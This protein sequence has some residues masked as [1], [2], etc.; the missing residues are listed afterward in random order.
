MCPSWPVGRESLEGVPSTLRRACGDRRRLD[1]SRRGSVWRRPRWADGRLIGPRDDGISHWVK[2][3]VGFSAAAGFWLHGQAG[4][5][6]SAAVPHGRLVLVLLMVASACLLL[7]SHARFRAL[8]AR[9]WLSGHTSAPEFGLA[10]TWRHVGTL[11]Y[12]P[13]GVMGIVS[14]RRAMALAESDAAGG[15]EDVALSGRAPQQ[16]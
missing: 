7:V 16:V 3:I 2:F 4:I 1:G 8:V 14:S 5:P 6:T 11:L 9:E 15:R 12:L 13:L 10:Y